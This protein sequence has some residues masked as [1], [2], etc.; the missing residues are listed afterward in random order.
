[1]MN[2]TPPTID[3]PERREAINDAY[4][5]WCRTIPG[6]F[7]VPHISEAF[8]AG[9]AAASSG[10]RE[11]ALEEAARVALSAQFPKQKW[12]CSDDASG[13]AL[14]LNRFRRHIATAIRAL[15]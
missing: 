11:R 10:E 7:T 13:T 1:M 6:E 9:Y 5:D 4:E 15:V 12:S 8:A 2:P 3:A 14:T